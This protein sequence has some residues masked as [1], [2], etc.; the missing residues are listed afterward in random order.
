LKDKWKD[1]TTKPIIQTK[2]K[3][4]RFGFLGKDIICS[5]TELSCGFKLTL[6]VIK[7]LKKV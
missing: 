7:I 2:G 5:W 1:P 6:S 3:R 4:K